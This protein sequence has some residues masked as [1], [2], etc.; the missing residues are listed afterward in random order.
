MREGIPE[1]RPRRE[2]LGSLK[3]RRK[4]KKGEG[5]GELARETVGGVIKQ[6]EGRNAVTTD[7]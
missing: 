2:A 3:E 7:R 4:V 5:T 1:D 6:P